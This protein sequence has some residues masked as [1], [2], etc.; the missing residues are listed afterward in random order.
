MSSSDF[1]IDAF[2]EGFADYLKTRQD[3][4]HASLAWSDIERWL[5]FEAGTYIHANRDALGISGEHV[6]NGANV[7]HWWISREVNR[8]DLWIE[9]Q[10]GANGNVLNESDRKVYA[11]EL[12]VC[13]NYNSKWEYVLDELWNQISPEYSAR[14]YSESP[15]HKYYGLILAYHLNFAE[16]FGPEIKR[17]KEREKFSKIDKNKY[18]DYIFGRD[19]NQQNEYADEDWKL[20]HE[21]TITNFTIG[22]DK[23]IGQY[24][25]SNESSE[26][27]LILIQ[28]KDF[29]KAN[30][31]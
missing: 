5:S 21:K 6:E 8:V 16:G 28:G 19:K 22:T 30:R 23:K 29:T 2:F 18:F 3:A 7:P 4:L 17:S 13:S 20:I 15:A 1:N 26:A 12:K 27:M 11:I 14:S 10:Y 9:Q 24:L 25:N 31:K